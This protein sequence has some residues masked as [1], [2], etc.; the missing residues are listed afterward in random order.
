MTKKIFKNL[1]LLEKI[2][3][4]NNAKL[5][6]FIKGDNHWKHKNHQRPQK[7]FPPMFEKH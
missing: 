1:L 6:I 7:L 5:F 4:T 3:S 2:N